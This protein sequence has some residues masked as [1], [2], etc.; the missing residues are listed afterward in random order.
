[1]LRIIEHEKAYV[2]EGSSDS[3]KA[4]GELLIQKAR[5]GANISTSLCDHSDKP[6]DIESGEIN[7]KAATIKQSWGK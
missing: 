6:I 1:M 5:L 3:L 2:I 7:S 4:L